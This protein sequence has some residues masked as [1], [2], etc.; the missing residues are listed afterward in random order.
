MEKHVLTESENKEIRLIQIEK[1]LTFPQAV[2][3]YFNL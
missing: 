2:K 3:I 1:G